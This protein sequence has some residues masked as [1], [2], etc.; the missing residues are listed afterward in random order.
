MEDLFAL[1]EKFKKEWP[2]SKVQ[3][4]TLEEYTKTKSDKEKEEPDSFTYWIEAKLQDCGSIWGGSS[5][6]FGIYS[7]SDK[8]EKIDGRGLKYTQKYAWYKKYGETHEEAFVNVKNNVVKIIEAVSRDDLSAIDDIDLGVA[9]KW[10]I[11]FHYQPDFK[12]PIIIGIF[13]PQVLKFLN[14]NVELNISEYHKALTRR[15]GNEDVFTY[16]RNLWSDYQRSLVPEIIDSS[17]NRMENL[18]T[19]YFGPPGTGKTFKV[20]QFLEKLDETYVQNL[21]PNDRDSIN[22]P[23]GD[24]VVWHLAP[25]RGGRLWNKLSQGNRIGYEW[26]GNNLG[27]LRNLTFN[28]GHRSIIKRFSEVKEGDYFAIIRGYELFGLAKALHDYDYS[29]AIHT[30]FPFQTVEVEWI[31]IF[32]QPILL[33]ATQTMAFCRLNNGTRWDSFIQGLAENGIVMTKNPESEMTAE[34]ILERKHDY[35]IVTFHQSYS[36]EDFIEGIKPVLSEEGDSE[37]NSISYHI[38]KGIFLL[39]CDRAAQ[40]AGYSDLQSALETTKAERKIKF[41]QAAPHYVVIDEIN[42]GNIA[43]IFGEL[44]TLIESDKRLGGDHEV[45]AKLPYSKSY[46]SVPANLFIIGTMNTADRSI[47]TLDSA[48]RRRFT[49][50]ATYPNIEVIIQPDDLEIDLRKLLTALNERITQVLDMDHT[51]GHA[52]FCELHNAPDSLEAL[53]KILDNKIVPQ[54]QEY[55]FNNPEK[56][57][58]ILGPKIVREKKYTYHPFEGPENSLQ[59]YEVMCFESILMESDKSV[60]EVLKSLYE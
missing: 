7:R 57:K 38:E 22:I 11:A 58:Q 53:V 28:N 46:F 16:A 33:N 6:K 2:L 10:K 13:N 35:E 43:N 39:A 14:N 59:E 5:F 30:D 47:E 3:N 18:N 1:C 41:N 48:L 20:L 4:M 44:I 40:K 27:D 21:S 19:I 23:L 25:G 12:N 31:R 36:Y 17:E 45:I 15:K 55:L 51:I 60:I 56:L 32:S 8:T 52:S 9:Y 37:D 49:F 54:L 34:D 29:R 24:A 50:K 42:R 26:C